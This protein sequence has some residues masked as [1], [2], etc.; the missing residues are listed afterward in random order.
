MPILFVGVVLSKF[1]FLG[2]ISRYTAGEVA[3]VGKD[4]FRYAAHHTRGAVKDLA[5]AVGEGLQ[6]TRGTERVLRCHRCNADTE[7]P[8]KFCRE[9]GAALEKTRA[10][11]ACGEL[12][13][14]DASFC[15]NCGREMA[16]A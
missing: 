8:A 2:A 13:D 15:D 6:A 10:C 11:A 5:Q 9:C 14:P 16:R 1:G 7:L 3:P 12:N 4:T